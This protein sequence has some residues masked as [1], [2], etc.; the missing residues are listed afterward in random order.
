MIGARRVALGGAQL[1]EADSRIV[2]RSIEPADGKESISAVGTAAGYGQRI[3]GYR[4]ETADI[5]VKFAIKARKT[6]LSTRAEVLEKANAWAAKA[7]PERGGAYM[8]VNYRSG[9]RIKAV[10]VQAPGEGDLWRWTDE[11]RITFRA[12]NVPYWEDSSET[13]LVSETGVTSNT[14]SVTVGG[15]AMTPL[16]VEFTNTASATSDTFSISADGKTI[17]FESLGLAVGEKL[18]IDENNGLFRA[19]IKNT[20]NVYRS[21]LAKRTAA[22]SDDLRVKPGTV[23]VVTASAKAGTLSVKY[24]G[25][26]I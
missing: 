21:V 1:D 14:S 16:S 25:R 6:D 8:T 15:S 26:Y 18:V 20:S 5:V 23:S 3:T 17:A 9:R 2:I 13:T 19:R 10:L 22:S 12:Y 4:R 11:F 24:R 7:A